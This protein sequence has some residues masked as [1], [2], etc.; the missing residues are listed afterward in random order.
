MPPNI[1][2]FFYIHAR[3]KAVMRQPDKSNEVAMLVNQKAKELII[4]LLRI[5]T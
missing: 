5:F 2:V 4:N 1:Y 3:A